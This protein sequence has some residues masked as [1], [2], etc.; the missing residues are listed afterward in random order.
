M[1]AGE[2][3]PT[4]TLRGEAN[5]N[6]LQLV[7]ILGL[8]CSFWAFAREDGE[9]TFGSQR[10]SIRAYFQETVQ[11]AGKQSE[12]KPVLQEGRQETEKMEC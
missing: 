5:A 11:R 6:L 9:C 4:P 7:M 10:K 2:T 8:S 3:P 1:Y 12:E